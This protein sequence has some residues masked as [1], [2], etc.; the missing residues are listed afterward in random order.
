MYVMICP[1]CL[2][3]PNHVFL[4]CNMCMW[5][6]PTLYCQDASYLPDRPKPCIVGIQPMYLVS[7][8]NV[9]QGCILY[10]WQATIMFVEMYSVYLVGPNQ[11][12]LRCILYSWQTLIRFHLDVYY[13]PGRPKAYVLAC[14]LCIWWSSFLNCCDESYIYD[15]A[16]LFMV[17]MYPMYLMK[18]NHK[19]LGCIVVALGL[20]LCI[21]RG[22]HIYLVQSSYVLL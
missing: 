20:Y 2:L 17:G 18:S 1:M 7:P 16:Q 15:V 19:L 3:G 9:L 5:Q 14:T 4:G 10:T 22:N 21:V 6:T 11:V 8:Y 12:L 13:V